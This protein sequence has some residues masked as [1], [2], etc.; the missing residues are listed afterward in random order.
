MASVSL[1]TLQGQLERFARAHYG[2]E[3][4]VRPPEVMPGHAG[5]SF[6]FTV[7]HEKEGGRA[8]IPSFCA[9]PR[10]ESGRAAT[11]TCSVR[12]LCFRLCNVT[13][14][15]CRPY[16]GSEMTCSGSRCPI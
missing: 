6:G 10:K 11:P 4:T 1:E 7:D 14:S 13:A 5:L 3:A 12:C 16:D 9:S 2:G 8:R 15:L